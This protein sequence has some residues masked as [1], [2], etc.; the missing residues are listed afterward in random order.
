MEDWSQ[1][2]AA[3]RSLV[4]FR[5]VIFT[6]ANAIQLFFERLYASDCD[7]RAFAASRIAAIG[8]ATA[9]ALEAHGLRADLVPSTATAEGLIEAFRGQALGGARVLL[10]RAESG[11]PELLQFLSEQG[12]QVDEVLLYRSVPPAESQEHARSVLGEAPV[13]IAV[14][15]SSSTVR[16]LA[17]ILD[18]DLS[19]LQR[20]LIATI[21]PATSQAVREAGLEVGVEAE[22]QSIPGIVRALV[23]RF[24]D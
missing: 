2:D 5:W 14:F 19:A 9:A 10:P 3:I 16:N 7:A 12:A 1:L 23:R 6:S 21:G 15:T 8:R 4:S 24:A 17:T 20:S 13:D 11:R 22:E 18:H